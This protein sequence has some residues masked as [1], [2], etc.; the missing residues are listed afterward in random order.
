[1]GR[2]VQ[3]LFVC[4]FY[5]K[6]F[7]NICTELVLETQQLTLRQR[8]CRYLFW[9]NIP[10]KILRRHVNENLALSLYIVFFE[11]EVKL[12][13][14]FWLP[15]TL[16][17]TSEN[18]YSREKTALFNYFFLQRRTPDDLNNFKNINSSL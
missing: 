8:Y 10:L 1:M 9:N 18:K 2:P 4:R 14:V 15:L 16:R 7:K 13:G 12:A 6:I 5:S 17:A 3:L 11:K